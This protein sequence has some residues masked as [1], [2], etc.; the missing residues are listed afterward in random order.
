ML[1][2]PPCISWQ[3]SMSGLA[4]ICVKIV[5]SYTYATMLQP[6]DTAGPLQ[7]VYVKL[8]YRVALLPPYNAARLCCIGT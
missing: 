8:G 6:P 2:L 3:L 4:P 1:Q 7:H 5:E